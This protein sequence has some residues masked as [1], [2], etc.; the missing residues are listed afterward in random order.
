M[1]AGVT[2]NVLAVIAVLLPA[3]ETVDEQLI[4]VCGTKPNL[5]CEGVW[6]ATHNEWLARAADWLIAKPF[7]AIIVILVAWL[8]SSWLRKAVTRIIDRAGRSSRAATTALQKIGGE[9]V[10]LTDAREQARIATLGT[11]ARTSVSWFVWAVAAL[12]VLGIFSINLG[13]LLAGAGIAAIAV[14]LGAQS[15]VR[16]CIAGFFIILEDQCGVGDEVDLGHATGT[17]ESLSLRMVRVRGGDGTLWTVPAG[18]IVRVG[19]RARS[20]SQGNVDVTL[21]QG[22]DLDAAIA[23]LD[24]AAG[25]LW[26]RRQ[27]E[28]VL[29][30]RPVVLGVERMDTSDVVLRM[31]LR[32]RPGKQWP[33]MRELRLEATKSLAT[34][35]LSINPPEA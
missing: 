29:V 26:D 27:A 6:N 11:V 4:A 21:P 18:S 25:V 35:G 30:E 23:A 22:T 2:T 28:E 7:A 8:I 24:E 3:A 9:E 12:V 15:F 20:W 17:V 1:P 33:L 10:T 14:G 32:T 34:H 13:P 31:T 5:V 16:D 19:N